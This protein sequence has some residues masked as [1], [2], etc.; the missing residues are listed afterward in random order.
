MPPCATSSPVTDLAPEL[1]VGLAP[2]SSYW[3]PCSASGFQSVCRTIV[4]GQPAAFRLSAAGMAAADE[5]PGADA[6]LAGVVL[7]LPP[8]EQAAT[9]SVKAVPTVAATAIRADLLL[10][11]SNVSLHYG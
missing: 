10:V 3:P 6:V 5:V 2:T 7:L 1:I 8:L 9:V 11:L 4:D